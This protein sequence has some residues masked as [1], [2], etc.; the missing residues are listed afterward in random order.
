M[1]GAEPEAFLDSTPTLRPRGTTARHP[2][3]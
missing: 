1:E 2:R 3:G